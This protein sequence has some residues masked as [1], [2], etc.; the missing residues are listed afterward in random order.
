MFKRPL[1]QNRPIHF[2][3]SQLSVSCVR[4]FALLPFGAPRRGGL[5]RVS[6]VIVVNQ[7]DE[8]SKELSPC[9]TGRELRRSL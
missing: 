8:M 1:R 9:T 7:T 3:F 6:G 5:R 2:A 4:S